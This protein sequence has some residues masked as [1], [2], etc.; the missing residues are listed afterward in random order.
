MTL[1]RRYNTSEHLRRDQT[2]KRHAP[3]SIKKLDLDNKKRLKDKIDFTKHTIRKNERLAAQTLIDESKFLSKT[4]EKKKKMN[5]KSRRAVKIPKVNVTSRV[6]DG[7]ET[8]N[9]LSNV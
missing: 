4:R 8:P 7:K 2:G 1:W 6:I 9:H 5:L 3:L